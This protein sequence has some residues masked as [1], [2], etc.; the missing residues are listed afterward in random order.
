MESIIQHDHC[1]CND[2]GE[3]ENKRTG[4]CYNTKIHIYESVLV[5]MGKSKTSEAKIQHLLCIENERK[6][7]TTGFTYNLT[8][9]QIQA[10][11][12]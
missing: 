2:G 7:C 5:K 11:E 12:V 3:T 9:Q 8:N 1:S 6:N 4:K 10:Y